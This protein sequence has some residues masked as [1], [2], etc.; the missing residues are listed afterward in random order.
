MSGVPTINVVEDEQMSSEGSVNA[1]VAPPR[2]PSVH[3]AR[4]T[5]PV[6]PVD[7]LSGRV[8][9]IAKTLQAGSAGRERSASVFSPIPPTE[10]VGAPS[11][12]SNVPSRAETT[13]AFAEVSS[14]LRDVSSQHEEVRA[15]MQSLAS[16]VETLRRARV[17]DVETT[18]QVQATLQR[19]LSASSSLEARMEQAEVSQ[20]QAKSAAAEA[21]IA[22]QRALQQ[23]ARLEEEQMRTAHQLQESLTAQAQQAQTSIAGATQVAMS[24]AKEVKTLSETAKKAEYTA[25][26]TA[27]KVE[28]QMAQL[29]QRI[30]EQQSQSIRDAQS[31]QEAQRKLIQQLQE[32]QGLAQTTKGM[33]TKYELQLAEVTGKMKVMEQLLMEQKEK[34]NSLS[35]QLSAAQDRIGGAERRAQQLQTENEAIKSELKYWNDLYEQDVAVENVGENV[36]EVESTPKNPLLAVPEI[37]S[38]SG[39]A[40]AN[41]DVGSPMPTFASWSW[42][43]VNAEE[44][45]PI[46]APV[47]S[48]DVPSSTVGLDV[49]PPLPM[50]QRSRRESFGS[51]FAGSSGT[52]GNGGGNGHV[53]VGGVTTPPAMPTAS[54]FKMDIKPKEPPVF[55]GTAAE[56]VDTWL[57]KVEDFIY[58]TEAN[59]RQQ[60]AYMATLLQDAAGDW[61]TALLKE[62]HGS[63]PADYTEMSALLR[64]RFGSS[65]RVD[66]AR[67][68]LRNIKQSTNEGV[69]AYSTRFESLLSKLPSFDAEWAKSQ[70]IWGLNQRIAELVVIAEPADLHAAILKAEKIEMARSTVSG[71]Q[72]QTS[73]GWPRIS[74]GRFSRGRGRFAAMQQA[75]GHGAQ[76]TIAVQ[77]QSGQPGPR[78]NLNNVQCYRCKGWGHMSSHCP[79]DRSVQYRGGRSGGR[80][81]GRQP[82]GQGRGGRGR[83]RTQSVNASLVASG[84]GAPAPPPQVQ[85]AAPVPAPPRPGN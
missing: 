35:S 41:P 39:I 13:Q 37:S 6:E 46:T 60:V 69:R 2:S 15:G 65:T 44:N 1:P 27:A 17:A 66:R 72:G 83:G 68:A 30:R 79:S 76:Q 14:V 82:R 61:W 71:N 77:N 73:G 50:Q 75:P 25:Q 80:S 56:D 58:L 7:L 47:R 48:F 45:V 52:G 20:A 53:G 10:V 22:S 3:S 74:R 43:H 24:T 18:A 54:I 9:P 42:P 31:A 67:A 32:A 23:A 59:T 64:K 62:R 16:G 11:V 28:E 33:T 38:S 5:S 55:R 29:E 63:R 81:R 34:G 21:H 26:L 12:P 51:T 36:A 78:L 8:S 57:A 4:A 19:T 85:D 49:P 84:P 70:Y 40:A